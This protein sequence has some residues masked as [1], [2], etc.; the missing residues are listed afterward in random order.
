MSV[1]HN[2]FWCIHFVCW[3]KKKDSVTLKNIH[4]SYNKRRNEAMTMSIKVNNFD[5]I[6]RGIR[7]FANFQRNFDFFFFLYSEAVM[8]NSSVTY[9]LGSKKV[10]VFKSRC[11]T[12]HSSCS[13]SYYSK[14]WKIIFIPIF[15]MNQIELKTY[16][17]C[18]Q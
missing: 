16:F 6:H 13:L 12:H 7:V 10:L 18:M 8:R 1:L 2:V 17:T 14:E 15:N 5:D 9:L 3:T 4:N 11:F